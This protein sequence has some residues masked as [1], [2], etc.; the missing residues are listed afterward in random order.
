MCRIADCERPVYRQELCRRHHYR[1]V[2]H[3]D[4]LA[5]EAL[6]NTDH[7]G[8]CTIPGCDGEYLARGLCAS[9]YARRRA[10]GDPLYQEHYANEQPC[11]VRGCR[12]L[13]VAKGYCNK[14]YQRY[15]RH[16]DPEISLRGE[17]GKGGVSSKGYRILYRP[18]HPNANSYGRIPEHRL[19]MAEKLGRALYANETVHHKNGNKL[20]NRPENLELWV[21]NHHPGQRV[22]DVVA[23]A[24]AILARYGEVTTHADL[25]E[26]APDRRRD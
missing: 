18:G 17:I 24:R 16:D 3:G 12:E 21:S 23:W 19:V 26:L 11:S 6:R 22:E 2:T 4:P 25:P 5:G 1:L 14:H 13:Q 20:D 15:L 7:A 8:R 10:H 9:H